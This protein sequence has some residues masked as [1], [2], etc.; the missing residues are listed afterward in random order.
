MNDEI[1]E[2]MKKWRRRKIGSRKDKF[3][4]LEE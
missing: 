2:F 1:V 4:G 3:K